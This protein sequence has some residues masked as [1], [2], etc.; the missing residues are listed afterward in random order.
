MF[1]ES[2]P[3]PVPCPK[4]TNK[5][6]K[7][8]GWLNNNDSFPCETCG[9]IIEFESDAFAQSLNDATKMLGSEGIIASFVHKPSGLG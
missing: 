8:V 7:S 9:F 1:D 6:L 4:C 2:H 5:T 3:L